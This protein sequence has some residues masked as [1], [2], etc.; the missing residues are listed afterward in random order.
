MTA[1]IVDI[2]RAD[3]RANT[4]IDWLDSRHSFSFAS[5]YDPAYTHHGLLLVRRELFPL[6][7]CT[8]PVFVIAVRS[9]SRHFRSRAE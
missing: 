5:H 8:W 7:S 6:H 3:D 2:R 4:K 1:P 9:S